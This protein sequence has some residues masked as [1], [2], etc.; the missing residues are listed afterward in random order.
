MHVLGYLSPFFILMQNQDCMINNI[1]ELIFNAKRQETYFTEYT[2]IILSMIIDQHTSLNSK[3]FNFKSLLNLKFCWIIIGCWDADFSPL[4]KEVTLFCW[5]RCCR[6]Q[7]L[8]LSTTWSF[9]G[10]E[11]MA[12]VSISRRKVC[13]VTQEN[14][15]IAGNHGVRPGIRTHSSEDNAVIMN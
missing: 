13:M 1:I 11:T 9:A 7:T 10:K 12:R 6:M 4:R 14:M 2:I 8:N 5:L 3:M 15:P